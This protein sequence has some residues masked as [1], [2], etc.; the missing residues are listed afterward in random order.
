MVATV[1]VRSCNKYWSEGLHGQISSNTTQDQKFAL[2]LAS[3]IKKKNLCYKV[4]TV[5]FDNVENHFLLSVLTLR[6]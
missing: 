1:S 6:F 5:S 2:I 3:I 4:N